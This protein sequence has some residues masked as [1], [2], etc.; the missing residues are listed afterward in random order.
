MPSHRRLTRE[1]ATPRHRSSFPPRRTK[2]CDGDTTLPVIDRYLE[3]MVKHRA[4]LLVFRSGATVTLMIGGTARPISSRPA[5]EDQITGVLTEALGSSYTPGLSGNRTF[6]YDAPTGGGSI[7]V[8]DGNEGLTV[9]VQ[10]NAPA[11]G[12]PA[13]PPR[14]RPTSTPLAAI[15]VQ[16]TPVPV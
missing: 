11:P 1:V 2:V 5:T 7:Q 9:R 16:R 8:E 13:A 14:I 6:P 10:P 4:D 15:D 12:A 3:A